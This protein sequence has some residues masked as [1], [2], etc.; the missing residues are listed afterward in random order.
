MT[1]CSECGEDIDSLDYV[2]DAKEYGVLRICDGE[3]EWESQD[4]EYTGTTWYLCPECGKELFDS[5]A[6]AI[7]FLK[8][9]E[10][11]KNGV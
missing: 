3:A 6:E 10:G 4:T 5:D 2:E 8:G 1:R 11:D 9:K 7:E